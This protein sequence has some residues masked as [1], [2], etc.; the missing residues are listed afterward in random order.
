MLKPLSQWMCDYCGQLIA[1]PEEGYLEWLDDGKVHDFK[2]VHH[3]PHSPSR[4]KGGDCYHH[5]E[6]PHRQDLSLDNYAGDNALPSLISFLDVGPYH[7]PDAKHSPRVADMR[8]FS[9]LMRRLTIPYYEEAR[10]Y[11]SEAE[12]DGFFAGA[13]EIWIYMPENLKDLIEQ[14]GE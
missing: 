12:A 10:L 13:N 8:E 9:E 6:N 2:I 5:T 7:D 4:P 11:W 1:E 14:Y 3:A